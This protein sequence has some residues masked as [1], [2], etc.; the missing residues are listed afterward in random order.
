[1]WRMKMKLPSIV[2][3]SALLMAA[4][5]GAADEDK[6][7][8]PVEGS[9]DPVVE[10]GTA[11]PEVMAPIM[12]VDGDELGTVTLT[13]GPSGVAMDI[14]VTGLEPGEHGMHFHETGVCTAP[15]FKESAGGHFNPMDKEHGLDNPE[16]HHAGDLENLEVDED[17]NAKVTITTDAVTLEAGADN[18]LVDA[19]GTALIIHEGA[20][21]NMTDPAGDSGTPF[22]CAEITSDN[23][24]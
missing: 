11:A 24:Q 5:G 16:G 23:V 14:D 7:M 6:D 19:D 9:G 17:G 10:E 18:S 20:D 4:C 1:M 12:N 8:D 2:L 13:Q 22:A 21:D 3:G 15:D